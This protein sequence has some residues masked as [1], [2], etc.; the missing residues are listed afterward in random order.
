MPQYVT[1]FALSTVYLIL[2][3]GN[4]LVENILPRTGFTG[5][6]RPKSRPSGCIQAPAARTNYEHENVPLS[7][8]TVYKL[9]LVSNSIF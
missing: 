7:V 1:P 2:P 4:G 3:A 5:M 9:V 8:V 6:S